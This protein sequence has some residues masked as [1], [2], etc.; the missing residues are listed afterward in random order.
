MGKKLFLVVLAAAIFSSNAAFGDV[1]INATNFPDE[2][3]RT[4]V[5]ENFDDNSDGTLTSDD[6]SYVTWIDV[7]GMGIASVKGIEFFTALEGLNRDENNLS[8]IDD[9][10]YGHKLNKHT[11]YQTRGDIFG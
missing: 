3:F 11:R 7:Q 2:I 6:I 9:S 4:Y 10:F 8:E 5:S 1:E